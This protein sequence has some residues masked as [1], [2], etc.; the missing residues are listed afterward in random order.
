MDPGWAVR[1]VSCRDVEERFGTGGRKGEYYREHFPGCECERRS[2]SIHSPG[3]VAG[4]ELLVRFFVSAAVDADEDADEGGFARNQIRGVEEIG[5]SVIRVSLISEHELEARLD[6]YSRR[7]N[8]CATDVK[9]ATILCS[10]VRAFFQDEM[11]VYCVYDSASEDDPFHADI[12]R[13]LS[14]PPGTPGQKRIHRRLRERLA[15][16]FVLRGSLPDVFA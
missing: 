4:E 13:G 8:V 7:M 1:P 16:R 11:R 2:V 12:H 6:D 14:Y 5:L 10:D 15:K 3:V 9:I